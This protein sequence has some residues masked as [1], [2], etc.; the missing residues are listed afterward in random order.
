MPITSATYTGFGASS[1]HAAAASAQTNHTPA[2]QVAIRSTVAT[3]L[4]GVEA[5]PAA[6]GCVVVVT[7]D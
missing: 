5:G 3:D 6:R 7:A 2:C 1:M 4:L